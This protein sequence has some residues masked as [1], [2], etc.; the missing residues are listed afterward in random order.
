M[1]VL[2]MSDN[3]RGVQGATGHYQE[4]LKW[5]QCILSQSNGKEVAQHPQVD[6]YHRMLD[7][8]QERDPVYMMGSM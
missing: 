5:K 2:D 1:Q 6:S 3:P 4:S 8:V 7:V